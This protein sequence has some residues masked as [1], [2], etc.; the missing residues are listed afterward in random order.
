MQNRNSNSIWDWDIVKLVVVTALLSIGLNFGI[1]GFHEESVRAVIAWTARV[2]VLLFCMAFGG[3][4][5]HQWAKNAF[6]FWLMMNRKYWGISF[7]ILHLIHLLSLLILQ[8]FFHPV[9][10]LAANF[11]L[12]AGGTAYVFVILMLLTS[13]NAFAK[14]LSKANWKRLHWLGGHW[15]WVVFMSSYWKRVF[16]GE[17]GFLI[18]GLLLIFVMGLRLRQLY[19]SRSLNKTT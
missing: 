9:F 2:D 5:F 4:A 18:L 6:S 16:R 19:L 15:I 8:Q 10:T 12:F 7:A 11:A 13:F 14:L 17:Y 3:T 1:R